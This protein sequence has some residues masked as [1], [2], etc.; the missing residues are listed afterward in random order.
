VSEST[1]TG[2]DGVE[3]TSTIH[4]HWG[5][6]LLYRDTGTAYGIRWYDRPG[7]P[8][9]S[10]DEARFEQSRP[11]KNFTKRLLTRLQT[12]TVRTTAWKAVD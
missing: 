9:Y 8:P 6:E 10:E 2:P 11:E 1:T 3:I 5:V 7:S 4:R 12:T